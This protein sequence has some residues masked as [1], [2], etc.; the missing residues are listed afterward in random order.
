[1]IS[2]CQIEYSLVEVLQESSLRKCWVEKIG[3]GAV[4]TDRTEQ[5]EEE[6]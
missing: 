4:K 2:N 3:C 1:M 6:T 5:V